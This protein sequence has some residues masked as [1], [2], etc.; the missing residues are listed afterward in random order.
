M[1]SITVMLV[2]AN[3]QSSIN[4]DVPKTSYIKAS[5]LYDMFVEK[6]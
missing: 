2:I 6:C 4:N 5:L 3:V 1:V